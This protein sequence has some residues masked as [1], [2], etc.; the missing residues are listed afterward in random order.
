MT[1]KIK[2]GNEISRDYLL[3]HAN[4]SLYVRLVADGM[5]ATDALCRVF[6]DQL[7]SR[8]FPQAEHIIWIST[9][10]EQA[11]A[12]SVVEL[13]GSGAWFAAL[14]STKSYTSHAYP[15]ESL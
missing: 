5:D 14:G 12:Q 2:P 1:L 3:H 9:V 8:S 13:I 4:E 10:S 11:Q 7:A 15:D 6:E